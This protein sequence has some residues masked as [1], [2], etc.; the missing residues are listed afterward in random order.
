MAPEPKQ[1]RLLTLTDEHWMIYVVPVLICL[2]LLG[3][4]MLFYY[5][6]GVTV[7]H[8]DWLWQTSFVFASAFLL[9]SLHGLFLILL[10]ESVS[11][12][13]ITSKR[14]VRF[15]DVIM[16]REE[17]LEVSFEKMKTVEARKKGIV[18]TLLNY[19]TLH[20]ENNAM[21]DYVPHPN[22]VAR[23]IEQMLGNR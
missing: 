22:R 19:G 14:V 1:E 7:F 6:A 5:I 4:S 21:I 3:A 9:L 15:H 17:M 8:S 18:R 20:F 13:V 12:I 16:F 2:L 11:Q 23:D 10:G